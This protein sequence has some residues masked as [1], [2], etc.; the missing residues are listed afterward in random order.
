MV[1]VLIVAIAF[2]C[3]FQIFYY[4]TFYC[5]TLWSART[6]LFHLCELSVKETTADWLNISDGIQGA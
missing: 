1:A 2:G 4:D 3:H 6:D 5:W